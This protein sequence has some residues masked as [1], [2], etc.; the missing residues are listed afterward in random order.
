[1]TPLREFLFNLSITKLNKIRLYMLKRYNVCCESLKDIEQA[2]YD[3][4]PDEDIL[5]ELHEVLA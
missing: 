5:D 1:M 4:I 2:I 3:Y